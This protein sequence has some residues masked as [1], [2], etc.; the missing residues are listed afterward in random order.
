MTILQNLADH[1]FSPIVNLYSLS[2]R[3]CAILNISDLAFSGLQ[4][5]RV[6]DL[7]ANSLNS[8]PTLQLR[9]LERLESL[10]LGKNYLTSLPRGSFTG[11]RKL[12]SLDLSDCPQLRSLEDGALANTDSLTSLSLSGCPELSLQPGVLL[13]LSQLTDLHLTDLGWK[14]VERDLVQWESL[15]TLDLSYNPLDC[16]CGLDWLREVMISVSNTSRA[17]CHSPA[18]L[19]GRDL[20]TVRGEEL[21]C[22]GGGPVYQSLVAGLCVLAGLATA[23]LLVSLL[24][25]HK[26]VSRVWRCYRQCQPCCPSDTCDKT[27]IR[28]T[29]SDNLYYTDRSSSFVSLPPADRTSQYPELYYPSTAVSPDKYYSSNTKSTLCEDDYFL[30]LSKDRKTFKPIRVCEL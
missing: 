29:F 23:L 19:A 11:L 6:L 25:C 18:R 21:T 22:G 9:P 30:S 20:R 12:R 28:Q 13:S 15:Q 16:S 7:S 1:S 10:S 2:L 26:K 5:L 4:S 14:S 27:D 3:G 8:V 24:H 17:V